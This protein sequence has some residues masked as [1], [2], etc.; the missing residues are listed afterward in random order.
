MDTENTQ[1]KT[2][3][4]EI[5]KKISGEGIS[6]VSRSHF[7]FHEVL[8]WVLLTG[9]VVLGAVIFAGML[10]AEMHAGWEYYEVTH[11]NLVTFILS[12]LPFVWILLTVATILIGYHIVRHTRRGYRFAYIS[13]LLVVFGGVG[14]GGMIFHEFGAGYFVDH[15]LGSRI[16]FHVSA[17]MRDRLLWSDPEAGRLMGTMMRESDTVTFV[18]TDGNYWNLQF[19]E[20]GGDESFL[21]E[22]VSVR[23]IGVATTSNQFIVCMVVP[24]GGRM[25]N[26]ALPFS[27]RRD[28]FRK[29]FTERFLT[30]SERKATS[31]RSNVCE[32]VRSHLPFFRQ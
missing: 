8:L 18:D 28:Q 17:P 1:T 12:T 5:L 19:D 14:F 31:S 6:P 7:V 25:E 2:L 27:E 32:G 21:V 10:F 4:D 23:L 11:R 13:V 3:Q 15:V 9:V 26:D 22:D 30:E 29:A 24:V 16:P 20:Y